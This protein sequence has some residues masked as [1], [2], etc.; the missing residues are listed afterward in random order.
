MK[1]H[2]N[3]RDVD[4]WTEWNAPAIN[5]FDAHFDFEEAKREKGARAMDDKRRIQIHDQAYL[6]YDETGG[7]WNR[8][9]TIY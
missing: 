9:F 4:E 7:T 5:M 6:I 1:C 8:P 3:I 2:H